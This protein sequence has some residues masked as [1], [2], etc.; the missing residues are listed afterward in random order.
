MAHTVLTFI[1]L[2]ILTGYYI[3]NLNQGCCLALDEDKK[4]VCSKDTATCFSVKESS[5]R[6]K[7]LHDGCLVVKRPDVTVEPCADEDN[8][9]Q[10]MQWD[11][12]DIVFTEEDQKLGIFAQVLVPDLKLSVTKAKRVS[13]FR[14]VVIHQKHP[15]GK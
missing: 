6:F 7:T 8:T 14:Q 2:F 13:R 1:I 11:G 12:S 9:A 4:V 10:I 3:R 5:S 15:P